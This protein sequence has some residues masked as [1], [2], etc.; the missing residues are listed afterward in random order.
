MKHLL[1]PILLLTLLFPAIAQGQTPDDLIGKGMKNLCETIGV[2]CS[3]T[4]K[5][6]R[7]VPT[8]SGNWKKV[9][10]DNRT[11]NHTYVDFETLRK[12][13]RYVYYWELGNNVDPKTRIGGARSVT[14]YFLVDCKRNKYINY[15]MIFYEEPWGRGRSRYYN[16]PTGWGSGVPDSPNAINTK[17]VCTYVKNW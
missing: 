4:P 3:Y 9:S 5:P 6:P 16:E 1:A 12:Q 14:T 10:T 13:G 15:D 7:S 17:K 2:G 11:G 8:P